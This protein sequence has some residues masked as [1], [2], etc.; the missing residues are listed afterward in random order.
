M[1]QNLRPGI[2]GI[3]RRTVKEEHLAS[4]VGTGLVNVYSTSMMIA[5]ME[6]A[7]VAAVQPVLPEG[8][9]TVGIHVDVEH[10]A[11][12]PPG[13][14]VEFEAILEEV[15]PNGKGLLFK[16]VAS[17]DSGLIGGGKHWRVVVDKNKFEMKARE[18]IASL[19]NKGKI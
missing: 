13:L 7:A 1:K 4:E 3:I 9:T 10:K 11:A 17:D 8:H 2:K 12:T 15:S 16:V 14:H 5:G 18:K 6:A 19:K